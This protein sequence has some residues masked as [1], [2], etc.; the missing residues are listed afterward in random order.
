MVLSLRSLS[1]RP[2]IERHTGK[3]FIPRSFNYIAVIE[4][5]VVLHTSPEAVL[6]TVVLQRIRRLVSHTTMA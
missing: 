1:L 2:N 4:L 6:Q 3:Y 5:T